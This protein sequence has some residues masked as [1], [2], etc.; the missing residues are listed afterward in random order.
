MEL[1][2]S[3]SAT[4]SDD[5]S[6]PHILTDTDILGQVCHHGAVAQSDTVAQLSRQL[7]TRLLSQRED[8]NCPDL[9]QLLLRWIPYIEV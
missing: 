1:V 5:S 2:I 7:L 9:K 6:I 3:G 4:S 8:S